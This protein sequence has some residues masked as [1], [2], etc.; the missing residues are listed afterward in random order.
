MALI[1]LKLAPVYVQVVPSLHAGWK[2]LNIGYI[3]N[4]VWLLSCGWF[5]FIIG[6]SSSVQYTT[7]CTTHPQEQVQ[8]L[9]KP[10]PVYKIAEFD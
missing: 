4:E 6:G 8:T 9:V 10:Q 7:Q 3:M 2:Y 5:R 1:A